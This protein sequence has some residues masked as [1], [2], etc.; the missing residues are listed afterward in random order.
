MNNKFTK[1]LIIATLLL[2]IGSGVLQAQCTL[3]KSGTWN[4]AAGTGEPRSNTISGVTVSMATQDIPEAGKSPTAMSYTPN[5]TFNTTNFWSP[6]SIAGSNSLEFVFFWDSTPEVGTDATIDSGTRQFTITFSRPIKEFKLHL[7]RLGGIDA[8]VTN[9]TEFTF[10]SPSVT[11]TRLSGNPQFE[12][13]GNKIFRTPF[14]T[15]ATSAEATADATGTGAGTLGFSDTSGNGFT[16]LTFTARGIGADGGGADGIEFV[17]EL[18][19]DI[20]IPKPDSYSGVVNTNFSTGSVRANDTIDNVPAT[21]ANSTVVIVGTWPAGISLNNGTGQISVANTVPVGV[22]NIQYRLCSVNASTVCTT[23]TVKITINAD[24]DGDGIADINDLDDDNDGILDTVECSGINAVTNGD[25]SAAGT[26]WTS[27]GGWQFVSGVVVIDQNNTI[28]TLSQTIPNTFSLT[29]ELEIKFD[30][31]PSNGNASPGNDATF[32]VEFNGIIYASIYNPTSG[33]DPVTITYMNGAYGT[34]NSLVQNIMGTVSV[35]VPDPGVAAPLLFRHI[36]GLD[37]WILDNVFIK[38]CNDTDGDGIPDY[39][40]LDSDNDGCPD[41]I[42]GGGSFLDGNLTNS[43]MPGGN[44]GATSGTYNLPIIRNLPGPVG[45]TPTTNGVPTLAGTGQAL[46]SSQNT[47]INACVD[48]CAI[49]AANPDSDGDGISDFCDLDDDNDGIL[50][51]V[52]CPMPMSAASPTNGSAVGN[53]GNN[54][55][56]ITIPGGT[57]D[58]ADGL[59]IASNDGQSIGGSN[60]AVLGTAYGLVTSLQFNGADQSTLAGAITNNDYVQWAFTTGAFVEPTYLDR[61]EYSHWTDRDSGLPIAGNFNYEVRISNDNFVTNTVVFST[62]QYG[63]ALD[64]NTRIIAGPIVF[65]NRTLHIIRTLNPT[66]VISLMPNSSYKVRMYLYGDS[67]GNGEI[68]LDDTRLPIKVVCD[69]DG[70]G[71]PNILDLDSDNDGCPDAAEGGNTTI[72]KTSLVASAGTLQGGNGVNPATAPTSGTFNQSV[73]LNLGNTVGSTA[74]TNGI[75]TIAGTGQGIGT[76]TN[77]LINACFCYDPANTAAA[78]V[79]TKH[80]I[81]LL[82]KAGADNGNWPMIR[83]SGFTALESNT[84]GFVITRA[85]TT[86]ITNIISPQDGMMVY[87]TVAKCL[88]LYDGS[89]WSCFVTPTCP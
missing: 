2:F 80:G 21:S 66:N 37:D 9:S 4:G 53:Y 64:M 71:I 58:W 38:G 29:G 12:V 34:P 11:M 52:E 40:D 5:G 51:T 36:A 19:P 43:T 16:T 67:D 55:G 79:D 25:F 42:E 8:G 82:Q 61:F 39:L 60:T 86:E 56:S 31:R 49:T 3:G 70:D 77:A 76:S 45:T 65:G 63:S 62:R 44:S 84:K 18:C 72:P 50:D 48:P 75:P 35:F 15:G 83:K 6:A 78:G 46:G 7:D 74:T 85:T 68:I 57:D 27:S 22:Y 30:L 17:M 32:Q 23:T 81:T 10:T 33:T 13:V 26:G 47:A 20:V 87:D 89:T 69:K 1:N 73:L 14:I 54:N 41:A 88:K 59:Y 24:S 28:Q